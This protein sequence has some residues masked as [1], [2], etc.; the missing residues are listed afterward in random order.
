MHARGSETKYGELDNELV[1]ILIKSVILNKYRCL[2]C[3][4]VITFGLSDDNFAKYK[5]VLII[6]GERLNLK[7]YAN[8]QNAL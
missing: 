3:S 4:I 1:I 2:L 8:L 6:T 5:S 7:W